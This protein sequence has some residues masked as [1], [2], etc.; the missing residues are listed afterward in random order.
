MLSFTEKKWLFLTLHRKFLINN[1]DYENKISI[2]IISSFSSEV[3]ASD[4]EYLTFT[5]LAYRLFG[6]LA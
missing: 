5:S 3:S 6:S 1:K 2:Q 4:I